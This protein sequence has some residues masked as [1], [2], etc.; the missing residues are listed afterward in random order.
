MK[1]RSGKSYSLTEEKK[2][3][4]NH[5]PRAILIFET[6]SIKMYAYRE[7]IMNRIETKYYDDNM[8]EIWIHT[9][10]ETRKKSTKKELEIVNEIKAFS[11]N[12][13]NPINDNELI[14][15]LQI[16]RKHNKCIMMNKMKWFHFVD[17]LRDRY[18]EMR[19]IL[20]ERK[21]DNRTLI[22]ELTEQLD[23]YNLIK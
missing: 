18:F 6:R 17:T 15:L 7:E 4:C 3:T 13:T 2:T 14:E 8:K 5:A 21:T 16:T 11:R 19:N 10:Y 20:K 9:H 1:L 12:V 22:T 23:M